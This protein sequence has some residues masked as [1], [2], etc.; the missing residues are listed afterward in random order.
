MTQRRI[1]RDTAPTPV[2]PRDK[3]IGQQLER[4]R[5]RQLKRAQKLRHPQ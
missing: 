1:T 3:K 5:Q 2:A 4:L